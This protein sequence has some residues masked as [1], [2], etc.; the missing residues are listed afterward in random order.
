[1]N[2]IEPD[3]KA[4]TKAAVDRGESITQMEPMLPSSDSK[5]RS[6]LADLALELAQYS[7]AFRSRLPEGILITLAD[8]CRSMNCYYSNLIEGH[9]THPVDIEQALRNQ[10]SDNPEKRNL[11]QEAA[12]HIAVQKW[13]DEGGLAGR[14]TTAG[15]ICEIHRRFGELLPDDLLWVEDTDTGERLRMIP[16]ALRK[17]DVRAGRYIAISPGALPRFIQRFEDLY[18]GLGRLDTILASAAAHHRLLWI[19]PF[20]DGNGRVGR[21][22]MNLMLASAGYPWTVVPVQRRDEY[23]AALEEAST[24]QDI[25]PLAEFLGGLV[26]LAR[27]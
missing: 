20:L 10:Y 9:Y 13:V 22:L 16:G 2:K 3:K 12:A 5:Q 14:A 15:S 19:H 17:R 6:E 24:R 27:G 23:M 11:Q 26:T 7:A 25:V 21:F 4:D 8:L 1:M 18:N